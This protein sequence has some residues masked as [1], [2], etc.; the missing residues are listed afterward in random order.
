MIAG[1]PGGRLPEAGRVRRTASSGAR[2][3]RRRRTRP[4]AREFAHETGHHRPAPAPTA[5]GVDTPD[6]ERAHVDDLDFRVE[7]VAVLGLVSLVEAFRQLFQPRVVDRA[8]RHVEAH[9]VA[10][11]RVA[12]VGEAAD[13]PSVLGNAVRLPAARSLHD[14][15][16]V[17]P[18]K[19]LLVERPAG[20]AQWQRTRAE[21]PWRASRSPPRCPD[22]RGRALAWISSS[23]AMSQANNGP[24]PPAATRWSRRVVAAPDRVGARWPASCR[25]SGSGA[26]PAPPPRPSCRGGRPRCARLLRELGVEGHGSSGQTRSGRRRPRISWASGRSRLGAPRP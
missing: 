19:S 26:P 9:L 6:R 24:A 17:A 15:F 21:G 2:P 25:T 3:C 16:V 18:R 12:A 22:G 13:E 10:L 23:S 4:R 14:E 7:P 11:A 20:G 8:R 5:R 1:P